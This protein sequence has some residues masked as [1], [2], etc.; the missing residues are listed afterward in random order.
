MDTK[1][2]SGRKSLTILLI[3]LDVCVVIAAFSGFFLTGFP[4]WI[5]A[6]VIAAVSV[7]ISLYL[8][9]DNNKRFR[10]QVLDQAVELGSEYQQYMSQ[11]EYPFALLSS[12]LRL[13]WYN[14][15]FRRLMKHE[16]C[17]GKT[18]EEI[19]IEWGSDK[20]DW[21]PISKQINLNEQDFKALM[22]QIRLRD[23]TD[24]PSEG[25]F[26]EVYSLSLQDITRE[27]LLERQNREMQ[28]VVSLIYVDNY[29]QIVGSM[30]ENLRPLLEANIYRSL[31]DLSTSLS[32]IMTRLE[33]DRF[34]IIFPRKNLDVLYQNNFHILEEVKRLGSGRF[35]TTLSIGV[36]V[37]PEIEKARS[38]ARMG[39]DLAMGRGGDQAVVRTKDE[40]K[41]F[42]GMSTSVEN[43]TR[44]RARLTAYALKEL[45]EASDRVLLMGHANPDLDAFGSALGMYRAVYE[46]K[47]PVNIVMSAA[48]HAAVDYL[49]R[50]VAEQ[51]AYQGLMIDHDEALK[52]LGPNT[53]LILVDVNRK[54]IAQYGD[55]L[56][57]AGSL[58]VI[59]HHRAAADAV[60]GAAI[61]YVEPFASSASEMVTELLQYM[62]ENPRLDPLEADGLFAGIA[63]DTKNFTVKTGVR[64]FEAAAY[65]KR[66][67]ADSVRVRKMFKNDMG[68][69][70][71]KAQV[72]AG[73]QIWGDDIAIATWSSQLPNATTVAA[74]AADEL[75]DIHGILASFVI[76]EMDHQ[77]INISARSLGEVNVQLIMEELGG[78]GHL[79]MAGAQLKGV[80]LEDAKE[81][82]IRAIKTI[83]G[84]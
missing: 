50:L 23:K 54:V 20:P 49:Y 58:A 22:S 1:D 33:R 19:G 28:S 36:G 4:L 38:Y 64:T 59:D 24:N 75:L 39:V 40:Q 56:D 3:L 12:N 8:I 21:D 29:D 65:L 41:F 32:G 68:D 45:I 46:M 63:L 44:V 78:G 80:S 7:G 2:N 67:G 30:D 74:Q 55:L 62:I 57:Y 6:L 14:E 11:W 61:S 9:R 18:L 34:Q 37:D 69:Y 72:V 47:K 79:S 25:G 53:L 13:V 77:Q 42:G 82:V 16:Q 51:E 76:T 81:Q 60:S 26:T 31:S 15:A 84:K 17:D 27:L 83:T 10:Q 52:Y 71:A 5:F 35:Q 66:K 70:K 48:K 73:A 43:T